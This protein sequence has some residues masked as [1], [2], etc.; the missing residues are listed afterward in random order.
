M[1][2]R[3]TPAATAIC[4]RVV[5]V[6]PFVKNTSRAAAMI[7]RRVSCESFFV[8]RTID[9]PEDGADRSCGLFLADAPNGDF[10]YIR[11]CMILGRIVGGWLFVRYRTCDCRGAGGHHDEVVTGLKLRVRV[12]FHA[13]PAPA[14]SRSAASIE[15][16]RSQSP[17][18]ESPIGRPCCL[19]ASS[20]VR[21]EPTPF[22][23]HVQ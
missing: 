10:T 23:R 4:S 7:A 14:A 22:S 18:A 13:W 12:P 2:P 20:S 3:V 5:L 11:E 9:V 19:L 17:T 8:R 15:T 16:H 1:A 6:T 21:Y